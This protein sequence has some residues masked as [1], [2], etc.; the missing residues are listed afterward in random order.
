M[1]P[2]YQG[3]DNVFLDLPSAILGAIWFVS[4]FFLLIWASR[5]RNFDRGPSSRRR[6]RRKILNSI[7]G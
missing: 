5:Q 6:L 4:I 3:A 1:I 2:P 7:R